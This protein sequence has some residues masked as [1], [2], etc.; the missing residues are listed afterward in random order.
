MWFL[1]FVQCRLVCRCTAQ[2]SERLHVV[3]KWEEALEAKDLNMSL[4]SVTCVCLCAHMQ[5]PTCLHRG[6]FPCESIFAQP[7]VSSHRLTPK[8]ERVEEVSFVTLTSAQERDNQKTD[9]D[10]ESARSVRLPGNSEIYEVSSVGCPSLTNLSCRSPT[11]APQCCT[12]LKIFWP[13]LHLCLSWPCSASLLFCQFYLFP[14]SQVGFMQH[15]SVDVALVE[16]RG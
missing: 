5:A 3:L 6:S 11:V 13:E 14:I 7:Q 10:R 8:C 4:Q 12:H 2:K 1:Y 9:P 16:G 15:G